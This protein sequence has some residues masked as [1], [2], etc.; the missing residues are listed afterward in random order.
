MS[1]HTVDQLNGNVL[2]KR[3]GFDHGSLRMTAVLQ[4]IKHEYALE[5]YSGIFAIGV[6]TLEFEGIDG[7]VPLP[8]DT[9]VE[10]FD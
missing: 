2:G 10:V 9:E 6:S 4:K 7:E 5:P 1:I 3:V 8:S